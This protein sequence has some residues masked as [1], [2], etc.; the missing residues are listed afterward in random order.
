MSKKILL[1]SAGFVLVILGVALSLHD[2]AS[3]VTVFR[4]LIGPI[5][6]VVGLILLATLK[7]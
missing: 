3:I 5:F 2:W 1:G 6:A 4:G 7:H